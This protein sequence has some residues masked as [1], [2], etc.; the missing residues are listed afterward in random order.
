MKRIL[1]MSIDNSATYA[2]YIWDKEQILLSI[3]IITEI[4]EKHLLEESLAVEREKLQAI[5]QSSLDAILIMDMDG[6]IIFWNP[7]A[8]RMFGYSKNEVMG[9]DLHALISPTRYEKIFKEKFPS[10]TQT[11]KGATIGKIRELHGKRRTGKEFPIELALSS[12]KVKDH[13][14]AVGIIRDIS[15]RK[16]NEREQKQYQQELELYT[17]LIR[18]DL[19]NEVGVIF[20]NIDAVRML[21]FTENNNELSEMIDSTE[22]VGEHILELLDTMGQPSERIENNI[23]ALLN[24]TA[25]QF[26]EVNIR[27]SFSITTSIEKNTEILGS[28]LLHMVFEN[29]FRNCM[30]YAGENPEVAINISSESGFVSIVF[31]DN[32]PGIAAEVRD[33]LFEKGVTTEGTGLGLYLSR[34]IMQSI[35][36][37]I[38]LVESISDQGAT[39]KILLPVAE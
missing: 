33:Q 24:K 19:R 37:S 2:A 10:F 21:G 22:A 23:F 20:G 8:E 14:E 18:H 34:K 9:K 31:S 11:G 12:R 25:S 16:K 29:L 39:F 17:S 28:K 36:G 1:R 32:G 26:K 30:T 27:F 5:T 13:W 15:E 6:K 7:A 3:R 35:G 38:E 4:M